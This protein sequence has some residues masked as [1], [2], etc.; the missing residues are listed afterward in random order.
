M[1]NNDEKKLSPRI[2]FDNDFISWETLFDDIS[3]GTFSVK[4]ETKKEERVKSESKV[5]F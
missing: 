5:L 4:F 1:N 2:T 3:D